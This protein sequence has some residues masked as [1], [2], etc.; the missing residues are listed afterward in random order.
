MTLLRADAR[1]TLWRWREIIAGLA[2]A[3]LG[4]W[5]AMV[6]FSPVR[7]LAIPILGLGVAMLWTGA[8]RLRFRQGGG[9]AGIVQI[10][11]RRL[12]YWGPLTGGMLDMD[13]LARLT[14]DP[15][16]RPAHW[17][18]VPHRGDTLHIPVDAEG[19][20]ALFDLFAALPGIRTER[21]LD[22]LAHPPDRAEVLWEAGRIR[23]H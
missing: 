20:D 21:M 2:V 10:V 4:V 5:W 13:D 9:G 6:T 22:I 8:Q 16:G 7:W 11:E 12:A 18:L 15:T 17:V 19:A 14:L 3:G 1:A 23:L